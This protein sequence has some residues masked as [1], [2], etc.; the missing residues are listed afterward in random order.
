MFKRTLLKLLLIEF[1]RKH[2]VEDRP[3][4]V[5]FAFDHITAKIH[6][7][8]RFENKYLKVLEE[9]V[10][11]K[12]DPN[13]VCLDIGANIG[14]HSVAFASYFSRVHAFEPNPNVFQ[15]LAINA[16]LKPN[17]T[18]W[19]FGLSSQSDEVEV[20]ENLRN[21]GGTG[22]GLAPS[23]FSAGKILFHLK[24]LDDCDLELNGQRISFVKIDVEG[25]E[26][27][28]IKGARQTLHKHKPIVGLEVHRSTVANG[29]TDALNELKAIGYTHF[30][31]VK[32]GMLSTLTGQTP[33]LVEVDRLK[34]KNYPILL[35]SMDAF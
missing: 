26:A 6:T 24:A 3:R 18:P 8:G 17:I 23:E 32:P 4:L 22:V 28:A 29:S 27:D 35:G 20:F 25:H 15:L 7:D 5:C 30:Y 31:E 9:G 1:N 16:K 13:G 34:K 19:C 33:R 14:N 10:F 21:A 11:N 2:L 12:L